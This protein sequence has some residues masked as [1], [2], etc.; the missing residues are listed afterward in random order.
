MDD[1]KRIARGA[2]GSAR[3]AKRSYCDAIASQISAVYA[4]YAQQ[5]GHA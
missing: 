5:Q 2:S 3:R 1:P 4:A